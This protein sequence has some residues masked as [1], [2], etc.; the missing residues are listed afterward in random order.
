MI[1]T[2]TQVQEIVNVFEHKSGLSGLKTEVKLRT[3]STVCKIF[4][5]NPTD[6]LF[7]ILEESMEEV[8]R[9]FDIDEQLVV[10]L[11][12]DSAGNLLARAEGQAFVRGLVETLNVNRYSFERDFMARYTPSVAGAESQITASAN[13]VVY[14]RRGAGKSMLLL[15][16]L[17]MRS[18]EKRPSV[19]IDI[20]VYSHREDDGAIADIFVDLLEQAASLAKDSEQYVPLIAELKTPGICADRIR[21]ISPKM[22][23]ALGEFA[24]KNTELFVFLDDF[25]VLD[26]SVQPKIL[27]AL[28]SVSRGNKIFVKLSAIE[29]LTRT[30][31]TS[32]RE[33]LQ[34]PNDAQVIKLDY[35]LTIPDKAISHIDAI[36]DAQA[37]YSGLP[38]VR[39]ICTSNQVLPRLTWVAAGVPRDALYLFSQAITKATQAGSKRISVS[40]VNQAASE[41]LTIKL[42]DLETDIAD[43]ERQHL[44]GIL[45]EIRRFCVSEQQKNA[46]LIEIR[47][48][49]QVYDKVRALVDL[50]LLHI[51]S[52]GVTTGE[53][54]RKYLALIL[55]Y[56][57]YTGIRAARSVDLFNIQS[58]R[59]TY[60]DLRMLPVFKADA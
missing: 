11:K 39:R 10:T 44:E 4:V 13:H 34:V 37:T 16:A 38:S 47:S 3:G 27:S 57:F 56:G 42:R 12:K 33:G 43:T 53:A 51:I 20:Q 55:D 32:S 35:N 41:T 58:N 8:K 24:Q 59:V 28:Y 36:L 45:E 7:E 14:G 18:E 52:E 1:N 21:R 25:H 23:R 48:Q 5:A 2:E 6:R 9:K 40:N 46:F 17:H 19:W 49:D 15:Y 50:R 22:R 26:K 60:R 54:G 31:D 29:T 30:Y